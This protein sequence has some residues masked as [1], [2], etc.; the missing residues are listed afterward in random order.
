[1]AHGHGVLS[2]YPTENDFV[3]PIL[4]SNFATFLLL[5]L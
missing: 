4:I 2:V 5:F 1:M 3:F